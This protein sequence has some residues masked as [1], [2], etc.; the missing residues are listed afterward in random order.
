MRINKIRRKND[1]SRVQQICWDSISPLQRLNL[2]SSVAE[3]VCTAMCDASPSQCD[4]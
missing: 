1:I 2:R 3:Y 4:H